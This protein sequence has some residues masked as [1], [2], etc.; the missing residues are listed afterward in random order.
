MR[1]IFK[2]SFDVKLWVSKTGKA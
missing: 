2:G 1:E